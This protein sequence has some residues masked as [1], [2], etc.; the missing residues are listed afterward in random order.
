[1][2]LFLFIFASME[3]ATKLMKKLTDNYSKPISE[4]YASAIIK[5]TILEE[6]LR[7][8]SS[9][10]LEDRAKEISNSLITL[11]RSIKKQFKDENK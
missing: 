4:K 11:I 5:I 2:S 8:L 6:R 3:R 10:G 1:M 7:T 9:L